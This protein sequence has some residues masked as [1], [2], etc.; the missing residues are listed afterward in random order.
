MAIHNSTERNFF[1]IGKVSPRLDIPLK[2]RVKFLLKCKGMSQNELADKVG[3]NK[4][5][6]SKVV[7][8]DWIPTSQVMMLI[9]R[10]LDVDSVIL[11]GDTQFWKEWRTKV[12]Y[13]KEEKHGI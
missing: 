11:F 3:I 12:G 6:M 2:E 13:P 7:N 1:L 10:E 5:T 9:A 4:G 8:G